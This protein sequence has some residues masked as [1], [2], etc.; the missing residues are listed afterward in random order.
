MHE[1]CLRNESLTIK[2][3]ENPEQLIP[4][5]IEEDHDSMSRMMEPLGLVFDRSLEFLLDARNLAL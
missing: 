3:R 1:N 4:L 5:A 2:V